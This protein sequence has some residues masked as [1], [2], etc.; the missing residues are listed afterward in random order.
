MELNF[1]EGLARS[2]NR[3]NFLQWSGITLAV[4]AIGCGNDSSGP[5]TSSSPVDLG[6]G[7][8][9]ILNYAYA[10]EQLEAAFYTQV[11][12]SFYAGATADE[13]TM[14]TEIRDHEVI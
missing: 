7:D 13:Q 14:L 2:T 11:V 6:A 1:L 5:G 9:G 3:R 4:A 8:T 12:G 10:L